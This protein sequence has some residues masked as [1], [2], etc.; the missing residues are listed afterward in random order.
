MSIVDIHEV[1]HRVSKILGKNKFFLG[2]YE[3]V[4]TI[5]ESDLELVKPKL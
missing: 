4:I 1:I 5:Y 2:Q 3:G